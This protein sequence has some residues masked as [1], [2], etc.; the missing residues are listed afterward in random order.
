M[1]MAATQ[2]EDGAVATGAAAA[3]LNENGEMK[4]VEP[5]KRGPTH[6]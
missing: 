4:R 2:G 5:L 3:W 1:I 6:D